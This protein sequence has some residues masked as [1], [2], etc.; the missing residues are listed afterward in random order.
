MNVIGVVI[1]KRVVKLDMESD[2][3]KYVAGKSLWVGEKYEPQHDDEPGKYSI[4]VTRLRHAGCLLT[5]LSGHCV[6]LKI[7]IKVF[8]W[9]LNL[10]KSK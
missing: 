7:I 10:G 8:V 6:F 3:M 1:L 5:T 9:S 2:E 4:L